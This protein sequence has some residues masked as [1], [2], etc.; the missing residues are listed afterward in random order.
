[1]KRRTRKPRRQ[2]TVVDQA[3]FCARYGKY[4]LVISTLLVAIAALTY[5]LLKQNTEL[6]NKEIED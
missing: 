5:F 1:M 3:S 4:L 6:E 2:K